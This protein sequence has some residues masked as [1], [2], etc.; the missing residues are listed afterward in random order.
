MGLP[1]L[2]P[3]DGYSPTKQ[4]SDDL[5][6]IEVSGPEHHQHLSIVDVPGLFHSGSSFMFIAGLQLTRVGSD[7][8]QSEED[9]EII[10]GM[11]DSYMKDKRTI[12]L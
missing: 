5:F 3:K 2:H 11:I 6:S 1:A 10:R 9:L 12:M 4:F 7:D 8:D